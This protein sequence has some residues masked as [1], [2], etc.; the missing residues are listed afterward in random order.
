MESG[1]LDAAAERYRAVIEKTPAFEPVHYHLGCVLLRQK[2]F[3]AAEDEFGKVLRLD[4][5][6]FVALKFLGDSLAAQGKDA[7]AEA[8]Y[9]AALQHP[10]D[11]SVIR[12]ALLLADKPAEDKTTL[13]R[14]YDNSRNQ[15]LPVIHLQLAAL[16]SGRGAYPDALDHYV[17][18]LRLQPDSPEALNN[19]AWF[20]ATCPDARIRDGAQAVKHAERACD[21]TH[22]RET[23]M[24]GTLAAAYAEAGRFDDAVATADKACALAAEADRPELLKKNQ[25]LL[26]RYRAH[27]PYHEMLKPSVPNA[28]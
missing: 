3:A 8:A 23:T 7:E 20:L 2:K 14:L 9:T 26:E 5:G 28:P 4:P 22:Y 1:K 18:A 6:N 19:L 15:M 17:E 24:V 27:E 11:A 21:L 25:E 10:S 16:Q 12:T 13:V